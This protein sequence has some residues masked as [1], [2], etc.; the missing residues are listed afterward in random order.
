MV[1]NKMC[2]NL[3]ALNGID[4]GIHFCRLSF[5]TSAKSP[6]VFLW[7]SRCFLSPF[8]RMRG[9]STLTTH[10]HHG[11]FLNFTSHISPYKLPYMPRDVKWLKLESAHFLKPNKQSDETGQ[12]LKCIHHHHHHH[13]LDSSMLAQNF[14]LFRDKSLFGGCIVYIT[15]TP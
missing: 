10:L 3:F 13:W 8:R 5:E 1:I 6:I 12:L 2:I 9:E 15:P 11:R 14:L 7:N 4:S